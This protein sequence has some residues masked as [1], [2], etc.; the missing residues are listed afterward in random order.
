VPHQQSK[1]T[2][3]ALLQRGQN[4]VLSGRLKGTELCP[5]ESLFGQF[6]QLL[7]AL[8]VQSAGLRATVAKPQERSL[9]LFRSPRH[10]GKKKIG[11]FLLLPGRQ[12]LFTVLS[13]EKP[14]DVIDNAR[15][16][17]PGFMI[18]RHDARR[19]RLDSGPL[20]DVEHNL[21]GLI[22]TLHMK[23]SAFSHKYR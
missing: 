6:I 22:F 1:E 17:R 3:P 13:Q 20:V 15:F 2:A 9:L 23:D 10:A 8:I 16:P 21:G 7:H 12:L 4:L 5:T 18:R 11:D 14:L 19:R